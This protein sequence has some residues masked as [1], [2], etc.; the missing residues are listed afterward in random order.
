MVKL[1]YTC[2]GC[3]AGWQHKGRFCNLHIELVH[4]VWVV[5]LVS[6]VWPSPAILPASAYTLAYSSLLLLTTP[7]I[8]LET[9][10][11]CER[12]GTFWCLQFSVAMSW[13]CQIL[14]SINVTSCYYQVFYPD[15][16]MLFDVLV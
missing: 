8:A 6:V 3:L 9:K 14:L 1:E 2:A 4:Q 11:V 13:S 10:L 16:S 12:I 7:A 5:G 15:E